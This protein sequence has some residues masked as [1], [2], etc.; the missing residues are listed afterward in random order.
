MV[1]PWRR[2]INLKVRRAIVRSRSFVGI[3]LASILFAASGGAFAADMAVKAPPPPP[4]PPPPTWTGFYFGG[5][6]GGG[7]SKQTFVDNFAAPPFGAVALGAIDSTPNPS[8]VVGGIQAGY[9]YQFNWLLL[10][11]EGGFTWS[12]ATSSASCF[13]LLAPQTCTADPRWLADVVGRVGAIW[14]PALFYAKGGAAWINTTYTDIALAGAP[15]AALPGVF[16]SGNETVP[17]WTVGGGVEYLFLP[18]WSAKVEYD[19]YG[20][21]DTNTTLTA[22]PGLFFT[23]LMKQNMQT[24]TVGI[25]YHFGSWFYR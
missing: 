1:V 10:G 18:N 25:N 19:Y 8:G 22:G 3:V 14:G 2:D 16:F 24:V 6:L 11:V 4:P 15:A 12:G 20:F 23:E 17:G 5:N 13:P 7:W 21:R 9:N